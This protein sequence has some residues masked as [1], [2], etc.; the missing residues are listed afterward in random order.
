[1]ALLVSDDD[2][3]VANVGVDRAWRLR[4]DRFDRVSE[5]DSLGRMA[6]AALPE[7]LHD[8]PASCFG[9]SSGAA[10]RWHVRQLDLRAGDLIVLAAGFRDIGVS[11]Q[12]VGSELQRTL[13][14][15]ESASHAWRGADRLAERLGERIAE[16]AVRASTEEARRRARWHVHSRLALA[17]VQIAAATV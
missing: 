11:E 15:S 8:L 12:Q 9:R 2:C 1:V 10:A 16:A 14:E 6:G 5:D 7:S 3:A 17:V 13:A 4:R